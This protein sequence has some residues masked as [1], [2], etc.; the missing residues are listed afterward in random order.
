MPA[1]TLR[2]RQGQNNLRRMTTGTENHAGCA[3]GHVGTHRE[4]R[5]NLIFCHRIMVIPYSGLVSFAHRH[6]NVSKT[7]PMRLPAR[8]RC[9]SANGAEWNTRTRVR[10]ALKSNLD[11]YARGVYSDVDGHGQPHGQPRTHGNGSPWGR[12]SNVNGLGRTGASSL[13]PA[14]KTA[15]SEHHFW[16]FPTRR[17]RPL[18]CTS[19]KKIQPKST[20]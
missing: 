13:Q 11:R 4:Q 6:A 20:G 3:V 19:S 14:K 15:S 8:W 16:L 18:V 1:T 7:S 12:G 2:L 10:T 5:N 9:S 17:L